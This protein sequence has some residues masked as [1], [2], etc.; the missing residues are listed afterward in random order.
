MRLPPGTPLG[1]NKYRSEN[2]LEVAA[3]KKKATPYKLIDTPGHGKLRSAQALS[4]MTRPNSGLRGVIFMLDSAAVDASAGGDG[5][6][7][8]Q[9]TVRY[10]HDVLL[11]LQRRPKYVKK[12]KAADVRVLVACNKQDLFTALPPAA[13]KDSLQGELEKVRVNR[14]KGVSAVD[15]REDVDEDEDETV[16]GGGGEGDFSFKMLE[17]ELG[18]A[19]DVVG[20]NVLGDEQG[21]GVRRWEEWIGSCL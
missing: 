11:T 19:V 18:V 14:K 6:A 16:L 13:I 4:Y 20:G 10:L 5:G 17:E 2:D 9:D 7:V 21:N 3:S 12:A 8:A 15:A 1:S